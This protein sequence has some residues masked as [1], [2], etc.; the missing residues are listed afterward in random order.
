MKRID[1]PNPS[2]EDVLAVRELMRNYPEAWRAVWDLNKK[3]QEQLVSSVIGDSKW[4]KEAMD[5]GVIHIRKELGFEEAPMLEKL[6]IEQIVLCWIHY[7]KTHLRYNTATQGPNADSEI[8]Y[9]ERRLNAA[10]RRY[11]RAIDHFARIRKMTGD[12]PMINIRIDNKT[13]T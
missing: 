12:F 3:V 6:L 5:A 10:Q 4:Q 7:H 11:L 8:N 1:K 2:K 9:H 13:A